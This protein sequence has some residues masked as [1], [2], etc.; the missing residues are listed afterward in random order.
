MG[1]RW[2]RERTSGR[3][4]KLLGWSVTMFLVLL[5]W[6]FFR[7]ETTPRAMKMLQAMA[8][9]PSGTYRVT[10]VLTSA[11][12]VLVLVHAINYFCSRRF[13]TPRVNPFSS[14]NG[15]TFYL[16]L[17]LAAGLAISF[18]RREPSGFIYFRF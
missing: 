10:S 18:A 14:V 12:T 17:G 8:G 16:L 9:H 1:Y 13:G 11:L 6:V 4:S 7:C 15:P 5:A 2:F 3:T